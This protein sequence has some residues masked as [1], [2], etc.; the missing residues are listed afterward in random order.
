MGLL[1]PTRRL[2]LGG[3]RRTYL[4]T[5]R[6]I[7]GGS[8]IAYWPLS[9]Q[10]GDVAFDRSGRGHNGAYTGVTLASGLAPG[11]TLAPAYNGTDAFTNIY[12]AGL[13]GAFNGAKGT[14]LIWAKVGAA[15]AWTDGATRRTVLLRADGNN[16]I[17]IDKSNTDNY[18]YF[19]YGAGGTVDTVLYNGLGGNT[20]W[21]MLGLS[22]D[23]AADQ[24]K[25]YAQGAQVGA[26]QT[27]LGTWS[28][29]LAATLTTLGATG[30]AVN[31]P[32]SGLLAH[33]IVCNVALSPVAIEQLYR[34]GLPLPSAG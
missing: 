17:S 32:W 12:S 19:A 33:A 10:A 18:V 8:L 15:G 24:V 26:T 21:M 6:R 34:A 23:K 20:G 22:W 16:S 11:R 3:G 31:N 2:L 5:V 30:T 4:Q 28:G 1:L 9:E 7:C 25:A 29:A 13:A 27:G 14:V